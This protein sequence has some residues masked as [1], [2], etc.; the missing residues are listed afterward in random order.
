MVSAMLQN[1]LENPVMIGQSEV[2]KSLS[3]VRI[4][5]S[6]A[7]IL[8]MAMRLSVLDNNSLNDWRYQDFSLLPSMVELMA[9]MV[10]LPN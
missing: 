3:S 1:V 8:T 2:K 5:L 4:R 10:P 6:S 9:R 7:S